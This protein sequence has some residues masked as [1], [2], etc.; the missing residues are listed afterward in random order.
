MSKTNKIRV[1]HEG[2]EEVAHSDADELLCRLVRKYVPN[3]RK[4]VEEF[5]SIDKWY[6]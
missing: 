1:Q 5:H 2:N 4:I 6:S 3:G